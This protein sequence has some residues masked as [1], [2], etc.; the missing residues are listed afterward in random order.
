MG[1]RGPLR[2][3]LRIAADAETH[4]KVKFGQIFLAAPDIARDPGVDTI[5]V[6]DFDIDRLGHSYFAQAEGLMHDIRDL[7][8]RGAPPSQRA[9]LDPMDDGGSIFWKLTRGP[10]SCSPTSMQSAG[11][12]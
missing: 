12:T 10:R 6:P 2:A 7:M 9:R 8:R 11:R 1:N 5:T 3:L 4:G